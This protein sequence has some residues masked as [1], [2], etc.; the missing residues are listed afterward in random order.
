MKSEIYNTLF[1]PSKQSYADQYSL[2][3]LKRVGEEM[4]SYEIERSGVPE[5]YEG[6][7]NRISAGESYSMKANDIHTVSFHRGTK[8]LFFEGPTISDTSVFLEPFSNGQVVKTFE[9]RP[10]MFQR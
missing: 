7:Q 1:L 2:G 4:G 6:H 8:V 3:T 10:W 5:N 9:T